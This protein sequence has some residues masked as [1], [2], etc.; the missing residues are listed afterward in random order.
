[1]EKYIYQDGRKWNVYIDDTEFSGK[2]ADRLA[3]IE[4]D[5]ERL[6]K[7][8]RVDK[9]GFC[10]GCTFEHSD[11]DDYPCTTCRRNPAL[12]DKYEVNSNG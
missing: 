1:M 12:T 10:T 9:S 2:W 7:L 4:Y 11:R 5:I 3:A 8:A 6:Y